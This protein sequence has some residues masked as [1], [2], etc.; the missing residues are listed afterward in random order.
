MA[1]SVENRI[2]TIVELWLRLHGMAGCS[3][4]D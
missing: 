3:G 2:A 4:V 1:A